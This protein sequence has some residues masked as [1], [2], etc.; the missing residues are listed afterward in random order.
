MD[1]RDWWNGEYRG[2]GKGENRNRSA[3]IAERAMGKQKYYFEYYGEQNNR[4]Y[5]GG[6]L[7]NVLFENY[8]DIS[9]QIIFTIDMP[10]FLRDSRPDNTHSPTPR[11]ARQ[12][13]KSLVTRLA[14]SLYILN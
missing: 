10:D 8:I 4:E 11:S 14:C 6:V 13:P 12:F 7:W 2:T 5:L 3:N 1:I 9:F